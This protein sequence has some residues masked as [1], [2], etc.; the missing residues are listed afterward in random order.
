MCGPECEEMILRLFIILTMSFMFVG[1]LYAGAADKSDKMDG[2]VMLDINSNGK[3]IE[4]KVGDEIQIELEGAG[5]TG[6]WW[7]FDG[8]DYGL[9]E[10]AGEETRAVDKEGKEMA[11]RPVIGIWKLRAKKPGRSV[12]RM[13]YYRAWEK[14]DKAINQFEI[15]ANISP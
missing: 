13:K 3:K 4:L 15:S 5:A 6:Y 12:I 1:N 11:G 7:Y 14:S 9:F 10:L 2:K 8:L